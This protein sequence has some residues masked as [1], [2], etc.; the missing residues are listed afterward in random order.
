MPPLTQVEKVEGTLLIH[1]LIVLFYSTIYLR[2]S[3]ARLQ[4]FDYGFFQARVLL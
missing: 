4:A 2:I 3:L 1:P